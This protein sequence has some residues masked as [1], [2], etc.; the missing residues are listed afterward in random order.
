MYEKI[1]IVSAYSTVRLKMSARNKREEK[2][3][4]TASDAISELLSVNDV[5]SVYKKKINEKKAIVFSMNM[6]THI[7]ALIKLIEFVKLEPSAWNLTKSVEIRAIKRHRTISRLE[8][9]DH[10]IAVFERL[11]EQFVLVN[12]IEYETLKANQKSARKSRAKS[13]KKA[14]SKDAK[15]TKEEREINAKFDAL[16]LEEEELEKY[17]SSDQE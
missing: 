9:T 12:K 2:K 15:Y 13:V 8:F 4:I 6:S 7:D 14:I 1:Y 10:L 3:A 17:M 5:Q 11:N 16:L